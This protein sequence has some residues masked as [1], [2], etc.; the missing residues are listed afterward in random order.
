MYGSA[1]TGIGI[2]IEHLVRNLLE[3][4]RR[5]FYKIFLMEPEFGGF[6]IA[7]NN[8][9]KIKV[10]SRWYG[11]R[12]QLVLPWQMAGRGINLMHF[13]HFNV[14]IFYRGKFI[15]TVHDLTP[16]YFPGRKMGGSWLRKKAF[17]FVF[18]NAVR[19]AKKIIAVSDYTKNDLI[20]NFLV[21]NK[22][23]KVVYEGIKKM[24]SGAKIDLSRYGIRGSYIL[25]VGV[26]RQHKNL[27]GLIK[28]F[29][30]L[31][32]KYNMDLQLV[33]VGTEDPY[34]P[35][36][37]KTW[38]KVG[39]GNRIVAPGFLKDDEIASFYQNASLFV[40]PSFAEGFGFVA[41]EAASMG[42][43]VVSSN[44]ASLPEVLG[45]GAVY[46]NPYDIDDMARKMRVVLLDADL[47]NK[48][49]FR[50]FENIKKYDWQKMTQETL[51]LYEEIL[52]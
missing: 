51:K 8:V 17:N 21:D 24:K 43:P 2:Y 40:V 32:K 5:N 10:G 13:P 27:V 4:D 29:D 3:I 50:A 23:I 12:E 14:P 18:G 52:R 34:Y 20:K 30:V 49:I 22:K 7:Q 46:F 42:T 31:I 36:I 35:E 37:R 44:T 48:L 9:E 28:A 25:Y 1:Q 39:L 26:W 38:E 11:W 19:K 33:L 15:T 47:R 6:E 45:D 41:L 16:L